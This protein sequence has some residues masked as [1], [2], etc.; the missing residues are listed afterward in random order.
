MIKNSLGFIESLPDTR[1]LLF[2]PDITNKL[3]DIILKFSEHQLELSVNIF[4]ELITS[5]SDKRQILANLIRNS[6]TNLL[7]NLFPTV[8]L[9]DVKTMRNNQIPKI[10]LK[11]MLIGQ[12]MFSF[13]NEQFKALLKL[14]THNELKILLDTLK[15]Y[16]VNDLIT[17]YN[18]DIQKIRD[19]RQSLSIKL[20]IV[21]ESFKENELSFIGVL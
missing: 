14:L 8:L 13:T 6:S 4:G 19:S 7:T 21:K 10:Q 2:Y 3:Y 17:V 11:D 12:A 16:Q 15:P 5:I 20:P 18:V 1:Y 9:L